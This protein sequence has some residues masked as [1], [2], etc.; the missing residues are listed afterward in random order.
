[1]STD[2][3]EIT[4]LDHLLEQDVPCF[5]QDDKATWR[6]IHPSND[7]SCIIHLCNEHH[8]VCENELRHA[9]NCPKGDHS[10]ECGICRTKDI[11]PKTVRFFKI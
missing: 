10:L 9:E 4:D 11:D 3:L 2:T 8:D 5:V 6:M 1:M 7:G